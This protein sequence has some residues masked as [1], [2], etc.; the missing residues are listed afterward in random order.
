MNTATEQ[1]EQLSQL[2]QGLR[3]GRARLETLCDHASAAALRQ[4][5][6]RSFRWCSTS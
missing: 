4:A 6:P 1:L 5:L 2:L 3:E